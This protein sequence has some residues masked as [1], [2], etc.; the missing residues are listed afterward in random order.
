MN[1]QVGNLVKDIYAV[2][3]RVPFFVPMVR[4]V[5]YTDY[6]FKRS[7][8]QKKIMLIY[9]AKVILFKNWYVYF[10]FQ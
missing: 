8:L 6:L 1:I 2:W 9:T 4:Q 5:K 10:R 7:L 3:S